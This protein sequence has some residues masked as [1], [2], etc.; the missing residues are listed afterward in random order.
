MRIVYHLGVHC[1]D[2]ERL[3]KCLLVNRAALASEG[4]IVPGPARYR[5]LLRDTAASLQGRTAS[6][7]TQQLIL[8]EIL[9]DVDDVKRVI[10]SWDN[11]LAFPQWVLRGA[12]YLTAGARMR[13]ITRI[14]PDCDAEF[15]LAIRNPAS[16]LPALL[17][18][19]GGRTYLDVMDGIDPRDLFWSEMI[20]DLAEANPGVPIHVWCDEDTPLIWPEVLQMVSGHSPD[21][22]LEGTDSLLGSLLSSNGMSRYY[23]LLN[24]RPPSTV[25]Q[26]RKIVSWFLMK[27]A[28]PQRME[29]SVDLPGWTAELAET[30][31]LQYDQDL[32]RI[33]AIPGVT[34]TLP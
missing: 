24:K 30:L 12:L 5:T 16:F 4:I 19:Q 6:K 9:E 3:L 2:E 17:K 21:I 33:A 11:F 22:T 26:R 31:T 13:S 25:T 8:D 20:L 32:A 28:L 15:H 29:V 23:N 7:D 14:F 1:T 18:M 27:L 34:L 10:L